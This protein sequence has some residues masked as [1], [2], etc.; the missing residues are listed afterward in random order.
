M[1]T[2]S[3]QAYLP[4]HTDPSEE[5]DLSLPPL[6]RGP[7]ARPGPPSGLTA[8]G[9]W[10]I[11]EVL[12]GQ[13]GTPPSLATR[14][15]GTLRRRR[16]KQVLVAIALALAIFPPMWAVYLVAWLV[17]RSRPRQ[18]SMRRVRRAVRALRKGQS[19][20]ALRHL[21]DAH[22]RDPSNT[23]ALY[24]MGLLLSRQHRQEEAEEVLSLVAERVPGLPEVEAA[25]VDAY[26]AL[27]QPE[28]AVHHAQRLVH[29]QPYNADALLKLSEAFVAAGRLDLAIES[30]RQ[31]PLDRRVLS[32]ALV[33][34]H[35]HLGVLYERQG[36][37]RAAL[38]HLKR[39]YARDAA[40]RDVR[41]RVLS[42]ESRLG[43]GGVAPPHN[44]HP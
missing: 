15:Q 30:L 1:D 21:Q 41:A 6:P 10:G 40:Y 17:R 12:A 43:E 35:F 27:E 16:R 3:R 22:F 9:R 5:D 25:L 31:S 4:T 38:H 24:W 18:Q 7:L 36:D 39:V 19:G 14:R 29:A 28:S 33:D 34:V 8:S 26:V 37:P 11:P 44:L 13:E 2:R 42:L 32:D 20:P 23:D